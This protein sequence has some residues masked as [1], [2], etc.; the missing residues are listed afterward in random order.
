[1]V[2]SLTDL[3]VLGVPVEATSL[4]GLD[5]LLSIVQM[6]GGVP[7]GHAGGRARPGPRTPGCWPRASWR[8]RDVALAKRLAAHHAAVDRACPE[9][10]EDG[11]PLPPGSTIGI[12]GGR[13]SSG[14]MLALAAARLGFDAAVL[15]PEAD[16]PA[17]RVAARSW[18]GGLHGRGGA[19]GAG[20]RR[21]T[22]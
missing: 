16:A 15:T 5:A 20:P 1:M 3:P 6:P 12:L 19:G 13:A 7:G 18:D 2:A 11:E 4:N 10:V 9:T 22:S 8:S 17:A 21:R 14:R